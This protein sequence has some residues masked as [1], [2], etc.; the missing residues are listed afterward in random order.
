MFIPIPPPKCN[1]T[2]QIVNWCDEFIKS[3]LDAIRC[4]HMQDA[5][6]TNDSSFSIAIALHHRLDVL[7]SAYTSA[8][9][10]YATPGDIARLGTVV[11]SCRAFHKVSMDKIKQYASIAIVIETHRKEWYE[12]IRRVCNAMEV[13][14]RSTLHEHRNELH[15]D[16]V[17]DA[18]D[19]TGSREKLSSIIRHRDQNGTNEKLQTLY[20][21]V[22]PLEDMLDTVPR[23]QH[24]L[25][26]ALTTEINKIINT[27]SKIINARTN[28]EFSCAARTHDNKQYKIHI[29][30]LLL[31]RHV[32]GCGSVTL[33]DICARTVFQLRILTSR[34]FADH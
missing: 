30:E 16:S 20:T 5:N 28:A 31:P 19:C 10:E 1:Q 11:E 14:I 4:A 26:E 24:E 2:I 3:V 33:A 23:V 7:M 13:I 6:G 17:D 34:M 9:L 15:S 18:F 25:E 32:H 12:S 22:T 29:T 21:K 27:Q 8:P